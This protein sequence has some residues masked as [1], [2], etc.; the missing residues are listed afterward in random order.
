MTITAAQ[1]ADRIQAGA[2]YLTEHP[3][4]WIKRNLFDASIIFTARADVCAA[5]PNTTPRCCALGAI[6]W[7]KEDE[8]KLTYPTGWEDRKLGKTV[9]L[10]LDSFVQHRTNLTS[11]ENHGGGRVVTLSGFNDH[12]DTTREGVIRLLTQAASQV[13]HRKFPVAR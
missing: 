1:V 3:D 7:A 11:P 10:T 2:D 6:T 5:D 12:N 8:P 9:E 4:R 13:R